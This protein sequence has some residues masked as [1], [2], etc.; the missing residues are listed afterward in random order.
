MEVKYVDTFSPARLD[1]TSE[2]YAAHLSGVG[3][4]PAAAATLVDTGCSQFLRSVLLTDSVRRTGIQGTP[5]GATVDHTM[6]VVLARGD[7]DTA[8]KVVAAVGAHPTPTATAFWS[9]EDFFTA[10]ARQ[11]ALAGWAQQLQRRYLLPQGAAS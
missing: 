3:I 8:R 5:G 2:R 6:A 11:P 4:G 1:P 10:A 9:H 7:D